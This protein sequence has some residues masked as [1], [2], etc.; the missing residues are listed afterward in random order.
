MDPAPLPPT[1]FQQLPIPLC[2]GADLVGYTL[3]GRF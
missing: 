1:H 2:Q 3:V